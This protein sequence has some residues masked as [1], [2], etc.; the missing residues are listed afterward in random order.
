MSMPDY[1]PRSK[2]ELLQVFSVVANYAASYIAEH[3]E[4]ETKV[5]QFV[6]PQQLREV[7]DLALPKE[8]VRLTKDLASVRG[9]IDQVLK[10]SIR[11][12]SPRYFNQLW[13]G[14]DLAVVIAEMISAFTN[15]STYTYEVAPV[16]SLMEM[17]LLDAL[18]K[19]I[20]YTEYDGILTPGGAIANLQ[21]MLCARH[22]A[23]PDARLNGYGGK[24]LVCFTSRHSHYTIKRGANI[25]GLGMNAA[26]YIAVD[27][28][29]KM[30]PTALEEAIQAAKDAGETPFFVNATCGTTVL[31]MC[32]DI[33]AIA[34]VCQK[35]GVW[36]HVDAA[37]GGS[38]LFSRKHRHYCA[39]IERADSVAWALSKMLGMSQQC[40]AF[41]SKWPMILK[42]TNASNADYLFH[43]D[44]T[45]PFDL[46]D[47]TL[48]CGRRQDSFKAWLSWRVHGE[49]GFE[50]RIDRNFA[51]AARFAEAARAR[52][53][54]FEVLFEPECPQ[55][56]FFCVPPSMHGMEMSEHR[57]LLL[58]EVVRIVR[59]RIQL[60]GL[61]L[62]NYNPLHASP[63]DF[64][65]IPNHFRIVFANPEQGEKEIQ[66]V[67]DHIEKLM[68]DITLEEVEAELA[69]VQGK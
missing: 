46:G 41:F 2:E 42:Q 36:L 1:A 51:N 14:T 67:L 15:S 43:D 62:V 33:N 69:K 40:A 61:M 56:C 25:M 66:F 58:G 50:Q 22:H 57:D 52:A 7:I 37:W 55:V 6:P 9:V 3:Y 26:R 60:D 30:K 19:K 48:N 65:F 20:G 10:Y 44:D 11:T 53:P 68:A 64:N 24:K 49:D 31:G 23:I 18:A 59:R 28:S 35:H 27:A 34:D 12:G 13:S 21:G 32:E 63:P 16:Y 29:G 4:E 47:K 5:V 45:K 54:S 38:A 8:G 17:E 39:G